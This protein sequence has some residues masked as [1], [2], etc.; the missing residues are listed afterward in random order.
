MTAIIQSISHS[1][2]QMLPL[3]FAALLGISIIY[4]VG[5]AQSETLHNAAHDVRHA[6]GFPCH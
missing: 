1:K 6:T 5:H 4:V 3:M 2:S